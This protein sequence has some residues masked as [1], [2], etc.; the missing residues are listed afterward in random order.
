MNAAARPT[1]S[2]QSACRDPVATPAELEQVAAAIEE[3]STL[4]PPV[5]PLAERAT[6]WRSR[7]FFGPWGSWEDGHIVIDGRW[8]EPLSAES[9]RQIATRL[10]EVK[11]EVAAGGCA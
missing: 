4:I 8:C 1:I 5:W 6:E 7:Q 11:R 9:A 10:A 2:H 3:V